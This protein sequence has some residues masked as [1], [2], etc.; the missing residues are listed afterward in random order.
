MDSSGTAPEKKTWGN[1]GGSRG[2]SDTPGK[3]IDEVRWY[4][5]ELEEITDAEVPLDIRAEAP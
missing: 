2:Q 1:Q 4:S 5:D 3:K